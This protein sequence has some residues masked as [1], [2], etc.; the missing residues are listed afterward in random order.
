MGEEEEKESEELPIQTK[1]E[2]DDENEAIKNKDN[3]NEK[4]KDSKIAKTESELPD[5]TVIKKTDEEKSADN[6]VTAVE[7]TS[8]GAENESSQK[9]TGGDDSLE[10]TTNKKAGEEKFSES[11]VI[12]TE[13]TCEESKDGGPSKLDKQN[14]T[15]VIKDAESSIADGSTEIK[16]EEKGVKEIKVGYEGKYEKIQSTE[17]DDN[18]K[19]KQSIM[20]DEKQSEKI[21]LSEQAEKTNNKEDV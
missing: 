11:S 8:V 19:E 2:G 16:S 4:E 14:I 5:I 1:H 15:N 12:A 10:L 3:D 13:S 7:F 9:E 6:Q 18:E 21:L 17:N 20:E